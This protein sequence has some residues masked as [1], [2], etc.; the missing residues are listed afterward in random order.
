MSFCG[1]LVASGGLSA[2]AVLITNPSPSAEMLRTLSGFYKFIG[3]S[4]WHCLLCF[5][6]SQ[7]SKKHPN[8]QPLVPFLTPLPFRGSFPPTDPR[9]VL[10]IGG[11]FTG[12]FCARELKKQFY[13]TCVKASCFECFL[14]V[15]FEKCV[16][17]FKY[18]TCLVVF[19]L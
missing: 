17:L 11:Q 4:N 6:Y 13:A 14:N 7:A 16:S 12:N 10:L 2:V 18:F 1:L 19:F 8:L 5:E 9:R 15:E 3:G